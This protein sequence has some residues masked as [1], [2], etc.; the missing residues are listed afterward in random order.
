MPGS[1][2]IISVEGRPYWKATHCLWCNV[3]VTM[4]LN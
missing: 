2:V 1:S 4:M 3:E